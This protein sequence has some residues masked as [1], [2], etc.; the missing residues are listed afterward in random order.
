MHECVHRHPTRAHQS[1][2]RAGFGAFIG[3][4]IEW[5]DFY[6][7]G[8]AAALVFDKVF[9]PELDGP[10]G[11]LVAFA[12]FW[13]GF[14]ARPIGGVIFGHYGDRLGRKKTLTPRRASRC[15]TGPSPSRARPS[16]T[17]SPR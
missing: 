10:I 3:S 8:T 6:I 5:F 14:L 17:P 9:F 11:T 4:T 13:V 1:R 12:T 15:C 7:Y 16:A 2:H